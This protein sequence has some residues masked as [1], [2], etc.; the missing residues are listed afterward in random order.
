MK[1]NVPIILGTGREGRESEL[2]ASKALEHL[3]EK[4]NFD[5]ELIDVRNFSSGVTV[6]PWEESLVYGPWRKR[7][8]DAHGFIIVSPEYNHGY[9]GELK[10]FLDS[11]YKEYD[12]KPVILVGV[13]NGSFGGARMIENLK[14][15]L[16]RMGMVVINSVVYVP[17]VEGFKEKDKVEAFTGRLSKAIDKMEGFMI[18]LAKN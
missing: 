13:S 7:A 2:V 1:Y 4:E 15:V 16:L 11:A 10:I 18:D 5:A 9:P 3:V 8:E 17:E 6:P 12:R 14:P